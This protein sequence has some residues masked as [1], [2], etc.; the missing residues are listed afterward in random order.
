MSISFESIVRAGPKR[1]MGLASASRSR[2]G[3]R[4]SLSRRDF[5]R[6]LA[7]T[8]TGI[9]LATVGILPPARRALASHDSGTKIYTNTNGGPCGPGGYAENHNCS[10]GCGPSAV[11]SAC[12]KAT[13]WHKGTVHNWSCE[14]GPTGTLC[15]LLRPDAC[16]SA[17][18]DADGW[19]WNPSGSCP[20]CDG[21]NKWR[22]HDGYQQGA[23][24]TITTIC[25]WCIA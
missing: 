24:G 5:V 7:A 12:C 2:L 8:A 6:A 19:L 18:P 15:Y 23:A 20:S 16:T 14:S 13:G 11:C 25:R 3:E 21:T 4:A 10:P 17:D 22:C 1:P 9:G